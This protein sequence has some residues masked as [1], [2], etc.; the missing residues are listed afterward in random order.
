MLQPGNARHLGQV[1]VLLG[2]AVLARGTERRISLRGLV[3][4][5]HALAAAGVAGQRVAAE[6]GV[7]REYAGLDEGLHEHDEPSGVAAGGG[8]ALARYYRLAPS[9]AQL[10][11]A[12]GPA[13]GHPVGGGGVHHA[14]VGVFYHG[15]AL[16]AGRVG[17]AEHGEVA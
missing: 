10:R 8:H 6:Q 13:G 3:L 17:Q 14:H 12:V 15:H 16:A 9:R 2:D 7:R 1:L 4:G 11:E 5:Y